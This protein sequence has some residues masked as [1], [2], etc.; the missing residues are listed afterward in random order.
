MYKP[1]QNPVNNYN[2]PFTIVMNSDYEKDKIVDG[3]CNNEDFI[4]N[5]PII[6]NKLEPKFKQIFFSN[7]VLNLEKIIKEKGVE[8]PCEKA[9]WKLSFLQGLGYYSYGGKYLTCSLLHP[10]I[11]VPFIH[12]NHGIPPDFNKRLF[13]YFENPYEKLL[14]YNPTESSDYFNKIIKSYIN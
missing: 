13:K 6:F 8:F 7:L 14:E 2:L 11:D 1:F 9:A 3:F 12:Y 4:C 5:M 10:D